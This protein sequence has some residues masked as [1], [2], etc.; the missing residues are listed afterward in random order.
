MYHGFSVLQ[1]CYAL[2]LSSS[3]LA[4]LP[5]FDKLALLVAALGHDNAHDGCTNPFHIA[6]DS[7]L[8]CGQEQAIIDLY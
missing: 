6:A 1:G 3:D 7:E 4:R 2:L 5:S 8:V